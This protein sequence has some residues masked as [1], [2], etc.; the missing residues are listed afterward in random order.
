[1]QYAVHVYLHNS[2]LYYL[3]SGMRLSM[4]WRR[5]VGFVK[6]GLVETA[7]SFAAGTF[8]DTL[9]F[10]LWAVIVSDTLGLASLHR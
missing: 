6:H 5:L 3:P 7:L 9:E 10:I 4:E 8:V 2:V 1:M